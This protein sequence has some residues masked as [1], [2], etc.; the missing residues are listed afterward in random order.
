MIRKSDYRFSEG[1]M[2]PTKDPGMIRQDGIGGLSALEAAGPG[3][4][5]CLEF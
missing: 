3:S 2:P 1:I 4:S 5:D